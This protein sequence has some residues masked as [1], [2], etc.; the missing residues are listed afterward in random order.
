MNICSCTRREGTV[1]VRM[2]HRQFTHELCFQ[3]DS[4]NPRA[5]IELLQGLSQ[6]NPTV[7]SHYSPLWKSHPLPSLR[8]ILGPMLNIPQH[9]Q[10]DCSNHK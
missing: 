5:L 6:T 2:P 3:S 7:F 4:L 10:I 8:N 1:A 9:L